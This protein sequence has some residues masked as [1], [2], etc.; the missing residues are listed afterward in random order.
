MPFSATNSI[1]F[2]NSIAIT[3]QM[4]VIE[5]RY[6]DFNREGFDDQELLTIY[7]TILKPRM[8][9]EK[10][11]ILL[12]QGKITKWFSGWGQEGI[13]VG[14]AYAMNQD[15]YILPMHRNLGVFTTRGI[16]LE[17]LFAQF[18]G[19]LSGFTK[20]RDRSFHFGTQEYKVVG[21]IS[22]LGPQLGIADGIALAAKLKKEKK[23]T[24]VF[25][26]DGGAS[27]GDFHE[28][29]NVASV[30]DLP[31][32]F[33]IENNCWGLSTPSS[34]QFRC[35][36]FIDK[37]IGYGMEAVQVNGN[38]ILEVINAVRKINEEIRKNPKPYILELMTFR[39]RGHEEA[40]G[41]KYYPEGLQDEW[42]KQ[43]PVSNFELYMKE[44]GL[45]TEEQEAAIK[46]E[47]KEEIQTGFDTAHA[48]PAITASLETELEDVYAPFFQEVIE[49]K[50]NTTEKRFIDAIQDGLRESMEKYPELVIM[51]QDIAEYGGAFKVTEG[52]VDQFGKE[53]V[54]NT[55]ICES[56]IVGAG[57]GLSIAGMKAVVEMQFADFVTCGFNQI[58]NNL[59]KMHWR[60]SQNADV[61]VRMP[62]GAGTA[63]GPFHSQS[64][65]AWFVHTPG[66][67]ILYPSTVYDAKGM[68]NAAI[69]DPNPVMIF[70]H[71][72]LYRSLKEEIPN[73]YYTVEIGKARTAKEGT[74]ITIITYGLGVHWAME[75]IEAMPNV[76]AEILD[77]RT[78]LPLDNEAIFA[79]ARKTGKVI[80]LHEDCMTGGIGGE[81]VAL[82]T[83]NCFTDLDAPVKRV[84]SLDTP[85]PFAVPLESQFLPKQRLVE[86]INQLLEY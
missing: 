65:E 63:A 59:A 85:V 27:E 68:M 57:L 17:R 5:K 26:G 84:A 61:V 54:R 56:A 9:E 58:V 71:K 86:A 18:Q 55:P 69:E 44:I 8:I 22:H 60:W 64:N 76:S 79:A 6:I 75:A 28:S 2:A 70:E 30:W 80:V 81:L 53:R 12:R 15:E 47:I 33:A 21:M 41:T 11:L 39:M 62:T 16:P 4:E 42:S 13:S 72:Y 34:E 50:G 25:T 1:N 45:L 51:G 37:G 32:I 20:G 48:E 43:D 14:C 82:I 74:D 66:L 73:D 40:S 23:S 7:K 49:G 24:I 3:Q 36:Q 35:K 10:M 83:E 46:K 67:K 29:L 19:K 38:N 31:V 52:F 78:L 77:L